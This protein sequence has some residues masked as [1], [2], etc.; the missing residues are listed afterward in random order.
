MRSR[1]AGKGF[2]SRFVQKIVDLFFPPSFNF[3]VFFLLEVNFPSPSNKSAKHENVAPYSNSEMSSTSPSVWNTILHS[4]LQLPRQT[5]KYPPHLRGYCFCDKRN[6]IRNL[7]LATQIGAAASAAKQKRQHHS[8]VLVLLEPITKTGDA[9][10]EYDD[11]RCY[12]TV[13]QGNMRTHG[14]EMAFAG[15]KADSGETM[16]DAAIREATEE[17]AA[18]P[19]LYDI[20]G[21]M[22]RVYSEPSRCFVTPVVA[23]AKPRATQAVD[24]HNSSSSGDAQLNQSVSSSSAT[25]SSLNLTVTSPNEVAAIAFIDVLPLLLSADLHNHMEKTWTF[26]IVGEC[27][28][29]LPCFDATRVVGATSVQP[30]QQQQKELLWGLT[31]Y[32]FCELLCRIAVTLLAMSAVVD[33]AKNGGPTPLSRLGLDEQQ[34]RQQLATFFSR[35]PQTYVDKYKHLRGMP[36]SAVLYP[37]PYEENNTFRLLQTL[38]EL[39]GSTRRL[40]K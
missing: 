26:P 27:R 5:L 38:F 12:L 31:S 33:Q 28:M 29:V 23:L 19:A 39:I 18:D 36:T 14:G 11:L 16:E 1:G 2:A 32:I 20:I 35:V 25:A 21:R 7:R 15:G 10:S 30:Q 8:A 6:K 24:I 3:Q 17:I 40:N 9:G 4:A 37:N 13:R 34:Q 22:S